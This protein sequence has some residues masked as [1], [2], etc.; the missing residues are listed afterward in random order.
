MYIQY[1]TVADRVSL[2][3]LIAYVGLHRIALHWNVLPQVE[4]LSVRL[5]R[6]P[7]RSLDLARSGY[8][9]NIGRRLPVLF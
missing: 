4:Y 5:S 3:S 9:T 1:S 2:V 8:R 6:G 7:E